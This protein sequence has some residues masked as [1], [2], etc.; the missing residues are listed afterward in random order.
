MSQASRMERSGR[1]SQ[2]SRGTHMVATGMYKLLYMRPGG[3]CNFD[4][5]SIIRYLVHRKLMRGSAPPGI[6]G[7]AMAQASFKCPKPM[8]GRAGECAAGS[9]LKGPG[10][11]SKAA[12]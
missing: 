2:A 9:N 4:P 7:P 11:T 3:N 6:R 5:L 8:A 1:P 12:A 10:G